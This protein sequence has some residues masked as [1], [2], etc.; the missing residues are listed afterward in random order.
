MSQWGAA[1]GIAV[2]SSR[3]AVEDVGRGVT[4]GWGVAVLAG[5]GVGVGVTPVV[6]AR[7]S[8]SR[9]DGRIKVATK[10]DGMVATFLVC[11]LVGEYFSMSVP[12]TAALGGSLC[13]LVAEGVWRRG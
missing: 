13:P 9:M 1:T 10:R 3:D 2:V 8:R 7:A 11:S 4:E 5:G 6:H 12:V